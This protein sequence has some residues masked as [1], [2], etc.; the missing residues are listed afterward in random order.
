[1]IYTKNIRKAI[2]IAYDAHMGQNDKFG[3]PYIFHPVHLAEF[4]DT[5]D[6]CIVAILHD[7]V[8]DTD[9]TFEELEKEFSNKIIEALKL[10]THDKKV[11]Y[12]EYIV[13]L[14]NNPIAKKVK[15]AD[16]KHN[17]DKTRL[18]HLTP[19][20]IIRNKKYENAIKIL[21]D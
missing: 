7:V 12:D 18:D 14:K 20:D 11:P 9:V 21:S 4:M 10:L 19:K 17:S 1:M 16:L 5:E 6:E 3:I 13:K 2:N 8:E 15:L